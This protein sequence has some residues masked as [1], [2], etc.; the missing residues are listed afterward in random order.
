MMGPGRLA[1]DTSVL[2]KLG[3]P[4]AHCRTPHYLRG[5]RGTVVAEVGSYRNPS[6]LA[7]HKPGLPVL[8]L[9]RVRFEQR[10]LW[11]DRPETRDTVFADLYETWLEPADATIPMEAAPRA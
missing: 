4:E 7:Y 5:K 1:P 9:Y 3:P 10:N 8:R 6:L 2:V 11:P